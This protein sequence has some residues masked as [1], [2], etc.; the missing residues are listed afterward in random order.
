MG[1]AQSH[2]L[3]IKA[4]EA[5]SRLRLPLRRAVDGGMATRCAGGS[6]LRVSLSPPAIPLLAAVTRGY[7]RRTLVDIAE[8]Q[9]AAL[10][11]VLPHMSASW[12]QMAYVA[13]RPSCQ[14]SRCP[15]IPP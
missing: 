14:Q 8:P 10:E 4:L 13:L 11:G 12:S 7:G 1:D 6:A 3:A 5:T 2:Q 15:S 9:A